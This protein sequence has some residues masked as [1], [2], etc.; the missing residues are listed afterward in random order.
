MIYNYSNI[1]HS[2][3]MSLSF[4]LSYDHHN[5]A[6]ILGQVNKVHCPLVR[7]NMVYLVTICL[8]DQIQ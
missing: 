8:S 3:Q 7:R 4:N 5:I 2:S 6:G 1:A